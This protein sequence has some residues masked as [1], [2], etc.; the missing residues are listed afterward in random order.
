VFA[1]PRSI[2]VTIFSAS[3]VSEGY[4]TTRSASPRNPG[5]ACD[6]V[7][8]VVVVVEHGD[9]VPFGGCGD[10]VGLR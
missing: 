2:I 9:A 4:P 7:E 8:V 3:T 1:L 10:E 5:R 6:D